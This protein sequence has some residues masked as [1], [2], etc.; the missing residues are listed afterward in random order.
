MYDPVIREFHF[1]QILAE[2][3]KN[4]PKSYYALFYLLWAILS[5]FAQMQAYENLDEKNKWKLILSPRF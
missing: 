4:F 2:T 5:G 1:E 3:W